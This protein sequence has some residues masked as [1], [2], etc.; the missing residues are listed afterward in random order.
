M[1]AGTERTVMQVIL[2]RAV[3]TCHYSQRTMQRTLC[4]NEK[5]AKT[6]LLL[7]YILGVWSLFFRIYSPVM[8][9][10]Y[11]KV[12]RVFVRQTAVPGEW[13]ASACTR[14]ML[15]S[16][17]VGSISRQNWVWCMAENTTLGNLILSEPA[18]QFDPAVNW[19]AAAE[20]SS[21]SVHLMIELN[22]KLVS[23]ISLSLFFIFF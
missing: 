21:S 23:C 6:I 16:V 14:W 3:Q 19:S 9:T 18:I 12:Y 20:L 7:P 5:S 2:F 17:A 1:S 8:K 15:R 22:E 10:N 4:I 11:S 13:P